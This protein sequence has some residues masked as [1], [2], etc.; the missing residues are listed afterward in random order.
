[1]SD[2]KVSAD[3]GSTAV[4]GDLNAP[5]INVTADGASTV[6]VTVE[7]QA[8]RELSSFLGAVIVVFSQQSLSE[9][10]R[11][12]R[13]LLPPE[14]AVKLEHNNLSQRHRVI[15]EYN[16][17]VLVLEKAYLGVEQT[18]A[19]ARFLVRRK[20]GIAY[21]SEIEQACKGGSVKEVTEYVRANAD[22]I[23][24]GVIE[25]LLADYKKSGDVK[26]P[27]E[28]AHFAISLIVADAV[29]ECEVFERP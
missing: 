2:P 12:P 3:D 21:Q 22:L 6:N 11:G 24:Q 27:Q 23:V 14:V 7:Q 26:V 18:N 8:A 25:R 10:G 20:A 28:S 9:Y 13:R 29:V 1:M 15:K 17:Y 16:Q 4:G 19:D 5:L